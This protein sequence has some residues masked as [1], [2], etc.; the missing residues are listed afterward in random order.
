MA[1]GLQL[2]CLRPGTSGVIHSGRGHGV[3]VQGVENAAPAPRRVD[4]SKR[5]GRSGDGV[6]LPV[7]ASQGHVEAALV[8][9]RGSNSYMV[10]RPGAWHTSVPTPQRFAWASE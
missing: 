1:K 6:P 9:A 7:A 4:R 8:G 10:V 2:L 3:P 5:R